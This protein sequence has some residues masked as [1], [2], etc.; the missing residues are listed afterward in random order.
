MNS[1]VSKNSN[2][3]AIKI[4]RFLCFLL[5]ATPFYSQNINFNMLSIN[6][7]KYFEEIEYKMVNEKI[8]VPVEINN[9]TYHFLLDTGAPNVISKKLLD[10]LNITKIEKIEVSDAN[11]KKD[12]LQLVTVPSIKIGTLIFENSAALVNDLDNHPVLKCY[13]IDGFI[14]SNLLQKS[15]LKIDKKQNK[16]I[17]TDDI[18]Q[19]NIKSKPLKLKLIGSQKA[20]YAE[21][22]LSGKNN[23]DV[24]EDVLIDTGMDGFYEMSNRVYNAFL[25]YNI[26]EEISKSVGSSGMG[27]FG[28]PASKEQI[29]FK[30]NTFN[31][32]TTSFNNVTAN[33]TDDN[34]SRVGLEILNYGNIII[35]F[36]SKK[37]YFEAEKSINLDELTPKY[38]ATIVDNKYVIGFV[39]DSELKE[40]IKFGDEIVRMDNFVLNQMTICD[41]LKLKKY[42]ERNASHELEIKNA[43][44]EKSILKI[45]P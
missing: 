28:N 32:N 36:K 9:K 10:E 22:K 44:N 33:T 20:P 31:F 45:N 7:K 21:V 17:I 11:D 1:N 25:K 4:I 35:D 40:K 12:S 23:N 43:V 3:N 8:I 18:K 5:I 27:L 38:S 6:K 13:N 2:R 41:I 42:R 15:I 14:G 19:L 24:Y 26:T 39:W 16:I 34:N 29:L 30:L 37:F